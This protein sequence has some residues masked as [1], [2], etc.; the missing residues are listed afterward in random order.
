LVQAAAYM[1]CEKSDGERA[2]L[3]LLPDQA[4]RAAAGGSAYG[5]APAGAYLIDRTFE[6]YTFER[7]AVYAAMLAPRGATLLDGELILRA[8]DA[9]TG[10]GARA[11]YMMFDAIAVNGAPRGLE[12]FEARMAAI[13]NDVR[14][15]FRVADDACL[16]AGRPGLP[17]Y[18]A[19]KTFL[20]KR[21]VRGVFDKI[22]EAPPGAHAGAAAA[23]APL[24]APLESEMDAAGGAGAAPAAP[25]LHRTY[26]DGVRVN[27]TDGVVFTPVHCSYRDMFA[28]GTSAQPLLKWKYLDENTI[29]FRLRRD[30]LESGGGGGGGSSG[31]GYG[32]FGG[33]AGD[34]FGSAASAAAGGSASG[35]R[36]IPLYVSLGKPGEQQVA[37]TALTL[38]ACDAYLALCDRLRVESLI[39][40]CAYD[41]AESTWRI[42]RVRDRKTRANHINTAWQTLETVAE[43]ITRDELIVRLSAAPGVPP[44]PNAAGSGGAGPGAQGGSGSGGAAAG[45][46]PPGV[47]GQARP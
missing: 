34:G 14:V 23:R 24:T 11:V 37:R 38:A 22:E 6:I 35:M 27:G 13:G 47:W 17:L 25:A 26:R 44:A 46:P 33:G 1:V 39:V 19:G 5:G 43:N 29:D 10:T 2:M 3:L 16:R 20:D 40:E 45:G 21:F 32:G 15:P 7:G 30:D 18:L 41:T 28:S 31:G 9:G 36:Q 8:D 42:K 12:G 4:A